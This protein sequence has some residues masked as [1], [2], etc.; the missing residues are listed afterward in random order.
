MIRCVKNLEIA[1][2]ALAAWGF[3]R[4]NVARAAGLHCS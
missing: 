2:M 3:L 4:A 1:I